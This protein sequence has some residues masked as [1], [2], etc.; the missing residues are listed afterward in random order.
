M[1]VAPTPP[2][3]LLADSDAQSREVFGSFLKQAGWSFEVVTSG[4]SLVGAIDQH[5]YDIIIAD[6]TMPGEDGM[7]LL[8][9]I[10]SKRPGQAVIAVSSDGSFD[11]AVRFFRCGA[12]DLLP[13]PVDF[14]WLERVVSQVLQDR[15]QDHRDKKLYRF[16]EK[17]RTELVFTSRELVELDGC[18]LP[19]INRLMSSGLLD[20]GEA[21]RT[22]LAIQEAIGNALEHGNLELLSEWREELLPNAGDRFSIM[23]RERLA[24]PV[25]ADRTVRVIADFDGEWLAVTVTDE[26]RGFLNGSTSIRRPE[27]SSIVC[28]GRG[29]ALMS[30]AVDEVHFARNGS[31][32]TLRKKLNRGRG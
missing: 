1:T 16:V 22:K 26:G 5:E 11:E 19:I 8:K 23:R 12:T 25:F 3:I 31:E 30:S 28:S 21:L 14:G 6:V 32:V 7:S 13:R 15:R 18:S 20:Q 29:L 4:R 2:S 10:L 17:E 27:A 9:D 24:D